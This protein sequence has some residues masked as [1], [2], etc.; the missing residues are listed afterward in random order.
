MARLSVFGAGSWGTAFA[1]LTALA[2]H[3]VRLWCR[4]PEQARAIAETGRNPDYLREALLPPLVVPTADPEEAAFFSDRWVLAVPA[5]SVRSL[6][7]RLRPHAR[8]RSVW[9]CDLAKGI[10]IETGLPLSRVCASVLPGIPY[11]VLSGPCL[12][13][14]VARDRPTAVVVA[15]ED[16][17]EPQEWQRL[18]GSPS[19]RVYTSDDVVGVE[20]GGSVKNVVAVAAGIARGMDL[21]E[22][23]GAA[24]ITRG[25]A[26]ILRLGA[27]MGADPLTLTGLAGVGDLMVTC[28]SPR[29]RNFR[30]G[31]AVGRGTPVEQALRELGQVAEGFHTVRALRS[32]AE[33]YGMEMP[34]TEGVHRILHEGASPGDILRELLLRDPK[35]ELPERVRQA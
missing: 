6:A 29:S 18:L 35:P 16:P 20:I 25:L 27:R 8:G 7:E 2:G 22:N 33:D 19:F 21:G 12:A 23:A 13:D 34:I 5:Q 24:L 1:R 28:H 3:P 4:R 10:E 17:E 14:E 15:S 31:L 11:S 26:E 30:L 9:V 32:H